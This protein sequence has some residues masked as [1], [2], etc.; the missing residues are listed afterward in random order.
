MSGGLPTTALVDASDPPGYL[1]SGTADGTVPYQ[2]SY[3]IAHAMDAAGR[4]VVL[5]TEQGY[6]HALPDSGV[7]IDQ[8]TDFFYSVLDA[9]H[10][11]R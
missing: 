11:Q 4:A 1:F 6:G 3:D 10:A 7:L 8:S 2:W 9:A 5:S